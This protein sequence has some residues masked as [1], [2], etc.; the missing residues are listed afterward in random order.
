MS[1]ADDNEELKPEEEVMLGYI[2]DIREQVES[3]S[4]DL[5]EVREI[6]EGKQE[7]G[8]QGEIG[9]PGRDG[10][11]GKDGVGKP[12]PRGLKGDK[13]DSI[14]G[15]PGKDGKDAENVEIE[16]IVTKV[17]KEV[18]SRVNRGSGN[19]PGRR[20]AVNSSIIGAVYNDVNIVSA[21]GTATTN[22]TTK[23]TTL[24]LPGGGT[25]A[26]PDTSVQFNDGGSFGGNST[27]T[28][29][30]AAGGGFSVSG[31]T[32]SASGNGGAIS[33]SG[34][35]GGSASGSGGT[36]SLTAGS[37][38]G[39]NSAGGAISL[40]TGSAVGDENGGTFELL[41]GQGGTNG[42]TGGTFN[43]AAGD[44]GVTSGTG[45]SITFSAGSAQ[46]GD[47]GGGSL[48]TSAGNGFG[49]GGGGNVSYAAG[50]SGG[51]NGGGAITM[52]GGQ[53]ADSGYAVL[54]GGNADA[55]NSNGGDARMQAGAKTGSGTQGQLKFRSGGQTQYAILETSSLA[56]TDKTFTFPN[57]TMTLAGVVASS[58]LTAQSAAI[59]ATTLYA[60]PIDGLF[61]V[62][63]IATITTAGD[64]SSVLG[65]AAGFQL[66]FTDPVDSVVKTSNPTTIT[67]SAGNTTATTISGTFNAY[68]K[69]GTNLQYLFGYTSVNAGVMVY[70]LHIRVTAL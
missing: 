27:F 51:G 49:L 55:S 16:P 37:A 1:T 30:K 60:V 56:T 31:Q 21:G 62:S 5:D 46:G 70:D 33:V 40:E 13:G 65:G 19:L 47:S 39:G 54:Q 10:R 59:T 17:Q 6:A 28:F 25:P 8:D 53:S 43:F 41:G 7:K 2:D 14:V 38:Q 29:D 24:T 22:S 66:K 26:S 58:D 50:N 18:L 61:Q 3:V 45:G 42:G 63:W 9:P 68:C 23:V 36:I 20:W 12:G 44:G 48:T 35:S 52:Q 67:S 34:G 69:G 15:P 11:D 64:V 57:Q 32:G 4:D